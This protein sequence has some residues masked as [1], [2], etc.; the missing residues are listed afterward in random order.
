[1]EM[2]SQD[3]QENDF[4]KEFFISDDNHNLKKLKRVLKSEQYDFFREKIEKEFV[5][6]NNMLM[7]NQTVF[8]SELY[9]VI[10]GTMLVGNQIESLQ[11]KNI[12]QYIKSIQISEGGFKPSNANP[13]FK[14]NYQRIY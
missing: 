13:K 11:I 7:K 9:F 12:L 6:I 14:E 4:E 1:M 2:N 5:R 3:Y 8:V 10:L